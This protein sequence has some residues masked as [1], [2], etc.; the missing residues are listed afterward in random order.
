MTL[1]S[2]TLP[3]TDD[4]AA[5]VIADH[6]DHFFRTVIAPDDALN[7][8]VCLRY[9][10]GEPHPLGNLALISRAATAVDVLRDAAVLR[11]G[12][13]PSA[14]AFLDDGT[15]EQLAA[16]SDLGF[17]PAESMPLMS[18]TPD[19][20]ASTALPD[21]YTFRE[22]TVN[23]ADAWARAVSAG[24]GLPLLVG[25]LFGVD[26]A[27]ARC[28]GKA[29]Y[30]AVE[31]DGRMVATSL[32]YL[33][34]GLAGIYGVATL[35]EHRGKGL[36]AHMTAEPLRVA[37]ELGYT[38]GLLQSSEMGAPVYSRIGFRIHGHMALLVRI[39]T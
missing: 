17:S 25:S 24:Y 6:L 29:R 14:I 20:L 5:A 33:H 3:T 28:P 37:W 18:V 26:R 19:T 13:F 9:I 12:A 32:V 38:T 15:P 10:T 36:G 22:V 11:E 1:E 2:R 35:P 8:S 27:A 7:S 21:E 30:F 31:H 4:V 34:D 23:E 16:A 39:P